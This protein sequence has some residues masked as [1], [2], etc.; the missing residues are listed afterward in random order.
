[1]TD[2]DPAAGP[3]AVPMAALETSNVPAPP[4]AP[5]VLRGL[6]VIVAIVLLQM[7]RPLLLPVAIAI[8]F[9]IVLARP[10][11]ALRRFGIG[12]GYGA[13]LVVTTL[14]VVIAGLLW[15]VATPA[16]E[17]WSRA[18]ATAH[19]LLDSAQRWRENAWPPVFRGA[20][21]S[22]LRGIDAAVPAVAPG[23]SAVSAVST[24]SAVPAVP[25]VSAVPA[26]PAVSAAPTVSAVSASP[27]ADTLGHELASE[28][29]AL[30]RVALGETLSF[31]LS[32][33]ATV[34]LL[35]FMLASHEWLLVRTLQ[36]F[37]RPRHRALVLSGIRESQRDI[38]LFI[39]TMSLVN[40]ALGIST[41]LA[42]AAIG[43]PDPVLWAVTTTVLTFIPY[44]GPLL[45]A[46]L[47]LLAGSVAFGSGAGMLAPPAAFLALH[48]VEANLLSPMIMG[49]R[50]RM[51]TVFV[52]LSVMVLGWLW[53]VAGAFIAVPSLLALRSIS[54]RLTGWSSVRRFLE[55]DSAL[56]ALGS[57]LR[58]PRELRAPDPHPPPHST[59]HSTPH[60]R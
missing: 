7:A 2:R 20:S 13:A 12:D 45:V 9:T 34:I 32:V 55:G 53:G 22:P 41:G 27:R 14:L 47:L 38:G 30:L 40:V 17:W 36:A 33:S 54:R 59:P 43:L 31:T 21:P 51:P 46:V 4:N 19:Q 18:P 5:W 11:R 3:V 35:F 37:R 49:H 48:A 23:A 56:P 24:R 50:L 60:S 28:G 16:A 42:L 52:F 1:M 58:G 10:V 26:V 25:A 44:L 15:G 6:F 29:L 57:L 39:A 8:L